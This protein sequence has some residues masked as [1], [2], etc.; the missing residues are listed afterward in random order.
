MVYEDR[1]MC[2]GLSNN[3][4]CDLSADLQY[5]AIYPIGVDVPRLPS[6]MPSAQEHNNLTKLEAS[7]IDMPGI[8]LAYVLLLR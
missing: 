4:R 5:A 8:R 3:V 6:V 7:Y 1:V 2:R